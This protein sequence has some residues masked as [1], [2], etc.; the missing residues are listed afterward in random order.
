MSKKPQSKAAM[1]LALLKRPKGA[2]LAEIMQATS[3]QAHTV[4][5]FISGTLRKKMGLTV[6]S[7]KGKPRVYAIVPRKPASGFD[8]GLAH[9]LL[10]GA[11][12]GALSYVLQLTPMMGFNAGPKPTTKTPNPMHK[13]ARRTKRR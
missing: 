13:P 12:A 10:M 8:Q 5:G 3:W 7:T 6:G 2:T 11:F 1:V 4:R 9:A